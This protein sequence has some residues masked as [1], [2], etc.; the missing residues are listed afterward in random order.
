MK[1][2]DFVKL[3]LWIAVVLTVGLGGTYVWLGMRV[4]AL[5]GDIALVERNS[6]DVGELTRDLKTLEEMKRNDKLKDESSDGIHAYF[7]EQ[8]R[9]AGIDP[10]EDYS[11][12][13]RDPEKGKDGSYLDYQYVLEFKKDHVKKRNDLL[14]FIWNVESQSRRIRLARAKLSLVEEKA[15]DDLWVAD[16]LTFVRRD[17]AKK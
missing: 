3:T 1:E 10:N 8:A 11:L 2:F 12:R 7:A 6:K 14:M 4:A 16:S 15:A 13:P 9:H 17:P 5:D